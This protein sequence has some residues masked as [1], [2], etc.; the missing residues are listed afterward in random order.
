MIETAEALGEDVGVSEACR[1]LG[2]PRR[3]LYR[4]RKPKVEPGPRPTP[5]RAL[6]VEEKQEV[7]AVLN[8]ERFCDSSPRAVY[9]ALLDEEGIY[10]CHW[11]TMYRVLEEH[12]E[13]RERRRQGRHPKRAKP[14]LRATGPNEV[15]SWDITRL[16]GYGSFY[17]LYTIIDIFSRYVTGWMIAKRES[18]ELAEKLITETCARQGI[19]EDQLVLHS[20]RGSSMRSK[21]VGDLLG[22]LGVA[23]SHSRPYTP[24]DNPYSESQ[25]KTM[26]Y[27][28]DYPGKFEGLTHARGWAREFFRWYNQSH[29]HTGLAL[30]TPAMVHYG[31]TESVQEQRQEVLDAAYLDHPERFVGGRPTPSPLPK[32]VWINQPRKAHDDVPHSDGQAVSEREPGAQAGSRE[33]EA[34]LDADE[35]LATLERPLVP[36]DETSIFLP[37]FELELCQSH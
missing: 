23:R 33:R 36:A 4:A 19:E 24:T 32:E 1:T 35:H 29:R 9:A 26:K 31:Q 16:K 17:Y 37:K 7:R 8:S 2:V 30:M 15:W 13:V 20:D 11:R 28:P 34:P 18:A 25:F 21:T 14:E 27:Q 12:D 22:D 3:S 6:S 10:L 5:H